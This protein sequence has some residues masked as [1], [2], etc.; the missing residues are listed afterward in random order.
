MNIDGIKE[1][2][3][4]RIK[5]DNRL[6]DQNLKEKEQK[7]SQQRTLF[8]IVLLVSFCMIVFSMC[9][10]HLLLHQ[11]PSTQEVA[12]VV[13]MITAPIILIL[14]LLRYIYDGG[15]ENSPKP[16]LTLNAVKEFIGVVQNILKK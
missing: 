11:K 14:A 10:A 15:K 16:T 3:E 1:P 12:I 8:R 2:N 5:N 9:E 4:E 13:F 7:K 6:F